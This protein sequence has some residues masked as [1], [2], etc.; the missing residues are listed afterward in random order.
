MT[1]A[2]I[3]CAADD[4]CT[5]CH[6]YI[7]GDLCTQPSL[8]TSDSLPVLMSLLISDAIDGGIV[9]GSTVKALSQAKGVD[10]GV[11]SVI[12]ELEKL[13]VNIEAASLADSNKRC[14]Y[15]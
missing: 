5:R 14:G 4:A 1:N 9:D 10:A 8:V 2:L 6:A 15:R 12:D 13:R 11:K 3:I 7:C